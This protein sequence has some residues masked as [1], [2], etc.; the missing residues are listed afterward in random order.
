M[1]VLIYSKAKGNAM[2]IDE[3]RDAGIGSRILVAGRGE[4]TVMDWV[5]SRRRYVAR[6][7][8]DDGQR[9]EFPLRVLALVRRAS[10]RY[11]PEFS[12]GILVSCLDGRHPWRW[13]VVVK[14]RLSGS[15]QKGGSILEAATGYNVSYK[16]G[17]MDVHVGLFCDALACARSR[18]LGVLD[19]EP[20]FS[21]VCWQR[22]NFSGPG[23]WSLCHL[24]GDGKQTLCG[25]VVPPYNRI[26]RLESSDMGQ[27]LCRK[28]E[29]K[30]AERLAVGRS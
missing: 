25:R 6:V 14:D 11:H 1:K 28:C 10:P 21:P 26:F 12:P 20:V 2:K 27:P 29:A 22:M 13:S 17:R 23:D 18:L 8:F 16:D 5:K 15:Y 19:S 3:L 30:K 4:A 7:E 9:H 24:S